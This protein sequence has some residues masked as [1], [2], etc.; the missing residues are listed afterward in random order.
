M[1]LS[2]LTASS[3]A[4]SSLLSL[5]IPVISEHA[6]LYPVHSRC[7]TCTA[8][9]PYPPGESHDVLALPLLVDVFVQGAQVGLLADQTTRKRKG[10]LHFLSSVF[11]NLSVVSININQESS[12]GYIFMLDTKWSCFLFDSPTH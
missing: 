9:V 11:A 1:L 7:G 2:N 3:L 6:S 10:E 8:P 5:N 12:M 4:C